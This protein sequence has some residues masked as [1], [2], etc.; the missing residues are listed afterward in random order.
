MGPH[1]LGR[2]HDSDGEARGFPFAITPSYGTVSPLTMAPAKLKEGMLLSAFTTAKIGIGRMLDAA[3]GK[4][5]DSVQA[6]A[7]QNKAAMT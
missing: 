6:P 7:A 5:L 2:I 1:R 3:T 4:E